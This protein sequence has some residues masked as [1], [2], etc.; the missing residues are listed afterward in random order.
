MHVYL[1]KKIGWR[2]KR[3]GVRREMRLKTKILWNLPVFHVDWLIISKER[4]KKQSLLF[5][6]DVHQNTYA[7][8]YSPYHFAGFFSANWIEC[9]YIFCKFMYYDMMITSSS[10]PVRC[11]FIRITLYATC[12]NWLNVQWCVQNSEFYGYLIWH[13]FTI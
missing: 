13:F 12:L 4:E 1:S 11:I 6:T 8:G 5:S 3:I 10:P 2:E 7:P 9:L